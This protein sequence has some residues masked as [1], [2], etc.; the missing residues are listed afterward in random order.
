MTDHPSLQAFYIKAHDFCRGEF[1]S[2][3][4][5]IERH[6]IF[7]DQGVVLAPAAFI[8]GGIDFRS[9]SS[10]K[11][12]QHKSFRFAFGTFNWSLFD[13]D[14][15]IDDSSPV[16]VRNLNDIAYYPGTRKRKSIPTYFRSV[17]GAPAWSLEEITVFA[18]VFNDHGFEVSGFDNIVK[19]HKTK[20]PKKKIVTSQ[21][22][23]QYHIVYPLML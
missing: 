7:K 22:R 16:S 17:G 19:K 20:P 1:V 14:W 13:L 9:W 21:P 8:E 4:D 6:P 15:T 5:E 23:R 3:M 12:S 18:Q 10:K 11:P 2:M